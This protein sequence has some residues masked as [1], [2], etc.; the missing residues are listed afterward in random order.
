MADASIEQ[1]LDRNMTSRRLN[2]CLLPRFGTRLWLVDGDASALRSKEK[3]HALVGHGI[4]TGVRVL[5]TGE[6]L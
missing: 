3:C 2:R 6:E 1:P 4:N 5:D